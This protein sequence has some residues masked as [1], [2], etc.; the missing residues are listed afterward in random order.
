MDVTQYTMDEHLVLDFLHLEKTTFQQQP[1]VS[2]L[3][4]WGFTFFWMASQSR[5]FGEKAMNI[6]NFSINN[7]SSL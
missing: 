2:V 7:K 3:K 1:W 6:H 5:I 4:Y